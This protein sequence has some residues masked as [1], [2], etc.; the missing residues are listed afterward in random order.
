MKTNS[1]I[2]EDLMSDI[3][4]T[5]RNLKAVEGAGYLTPTAE[6]SLGLAIAQ[7]ECAIASVRMAHSFE[8]RFGSE[9]L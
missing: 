2:L 3:I 4:E 8:I 1:E 5:S 9:V 6:N 7:L